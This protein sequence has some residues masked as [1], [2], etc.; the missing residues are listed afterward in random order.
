MNI[1]DLKIGEAKEIAAL[2]GS[3]TAPQ[4]NKKTIF[5]DIIGKYVIVRS[6]NE[7]INAGFVEAADET[8]IILTDCRRFWYHKPLSKNESW[9]EG[10]ANTGVSS[11]SKLSAEVQSKIIVEDYSITRCTDKAILSIRG[12]KAHEQN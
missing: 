3:I 4:S 12:I 10:V 11:N 8:G 2:F 5:N 7:G 6:R 1:D 9:Y